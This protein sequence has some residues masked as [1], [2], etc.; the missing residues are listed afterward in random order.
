M[1]RPILSRNDFSKY[2]LGLSVIIL[3]F[4]SFGSKS[5]AQACASLQGVPLSVCRSNIPVTY[6]LNGYNSSNT[7]AFTVISGSAVVNSAGIP[8]IGITWNS[9]GDVVIVMTE[10]IPPIPGGICTPDTIRVRVSDLFAPQV[11]CNDTVNVSLDETC[12][13]VVKADMVLEGTGWNALDYTIIVRDAFTKIP[14]SGSPNVNSTHV[15]KFLEVAAIHQCSGNFCWGILRVEDKLKPKLQCRSLIVN[16]G[17]P[18]LPTSPGIGFPKPTGAPNPTA[19]AGQPRTYTSTSNLYDNCSNTT[20]NYTDRRIEVPCPPPA[21]YL[22]T[23]FRDW[24]ATDGYGNITQCSDTILVRPGYIDSVKCPP[25]YDGFELPAL[26]CNANFPKDAEGNPHPSH[27]GFPTGIGCRN[28]NYA[29]NDLKLNVCAGSYK[30][31]REWLIVD[32]CTGRDTECTQL[33]KIVDDR[34][35]VVNCRPAQTVSTIGNSCTGIATVGL[36]T[37]QNECSLPVSYDVVVKR[38]VA[39]PRIPPNSLEATHEGVIRNN[40]N[41][42]TYTIINLPVGLS[43]VLFIVTDACGNSSECATEVLVEEKTKPIPVCHLETVVGLST[44]G[45]ARVYAESFDDGSYDNCALDSILVRRM[46]TSVCGGAGNKFFSPYI[47]FCCDDV[48]KSPINVIMRVKDKAGNIN[49]CMVLAYI[50]DKKPPVVTCLPNITVSCSFDYSNLEVFGNYRFNEA[51]RRNI[52]LNDAGNTSSSQPRNWGRD[53]LAIEDCKLDTTYRVVRNIN[54]CGVGTIT[55]TFTFR[56]AFNPALTCSQVITIV[57]FTPFN[58]SSI[59]PARDTIVNGCLNSTDPSVTG[60]PT[61]PANLSCT[62]LSST[63]TDQVFNQVENACYKILR[64]WVVIDDCNNNFF[65]SRVQVIK[66]ANGSGPSFAAGTCNNR[67]YDILNANC[68]GFIELIGI[69]GDDCTDTTDLVWSYKI[70]LGNNNSVDA[71]GTTNNASGVYG[72]GTHRITWT[73]EDRCG[74]SSTC[75]YTFTG[76]DKKAPTPFCRTGII[77]VIMPSSGNV[78]VWAS[79]LNLNSSDNCSPANALRYSFTSNV[80][81]TSKRYTCDSIPNGVSKTFDVRVYVTDEA[82]NQEYCDTKIIIQDGLGNACRDNLTGGGNTS[83]ALVSG[84]IQTG[85]NKSL[86]EA[87]VSINGNMPSMPKYH[88][89]QADGRFA[90]PEIPM[91][92]NYFVKAEK[93]NDYLNGVSTQDIVMIQKHILGINT[94]ADPYKI[95]AADVNDSRSITSKDIS[96]IRKLILGINNEFPVKKSWR[97]INAG[98][99]FADATNPWP[100]EESVSLQQLA[101]DVMNSNL[102]AVKL[103][104][105]SGNAKTSSALGTQSRTSEVKTIYVPEL[106]FESQEMIHVPVYLSDKILATG[107]QMQLEFDTDLMRFESILNGTC[108]LNETHINLAWAENGIIRLS[109]DDAKGLSPDNALFT[110]VFKGVRK[111]NVSENLALSVDQFENEIYFGSD[112]SASLKLN[113]RNSEEKN[114]NGFYLYQNQPNPFN[115]TTIIS[116]VLPKDEFASLKIFDVNGRMLKEISRNFKAGFNSIQ[117]DKKEFEYGGILYYNLETSKNRASRKMIM[118]E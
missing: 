16:C 21:T 102:I 117:L 32:W 46:D 41:P 20:F 64:R 6:F 69:A 89:T 10:I 115:T 47:D 12:R 78:D 62:K 26:L 105:V 104:D 94:I 22:D 90:F 98:Q 70:D 76:S 118:I 109:W 54:S 111:G 24:T 96:D 103:G 112:A 2:W 27:T 45:W 108:I 19:V 25:N 116:F 92:E 114:V 65:W 17:A 113:F 50:Q 15:G 67:T 95:I 42:V 29:Y 68:T 80:N 34:G 74:N 7:Y 51:D 93:N 28:I 52:I 77:T 55:R 91:G 35:P 49:E 33:I 43:W 99:Q 44:E 87:M 100:I 14:I 72:R 57:N 63:Y 82:N 3:L 23:V 13:G 110:L 36:P 71:N 30:I 53:G 37:I 101:G 5:H 4:S 107:L 18:I 66:V 40:T 61:W 60:R 31:I 58:G 79:D 75:S 81:T 8:N 88:M 83:S 59:V 39:D 48:A 56:D 86:E 11:N 85:L 73:V 84:T 9:S 1:K 38:G 106:E 97:F